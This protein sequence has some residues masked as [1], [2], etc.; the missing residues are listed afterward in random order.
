MN[1][2]HLSF[3]PLGQAAESYKLSRTIVD[4]L[5]TQDPS[6]TLTS[7]VIG[8]G[9]G[10]GG[11]PHI[12]ANYLA[13]SEELIQE[14]ESSDVVV[15]GTPMHNWTV[16]SALKAWIDHVIR[17][18]RTFHGTAQGKP[19]ALHDRPVFFAIASGAKFSGEGARQPDFLTP[20]LKFALGTIGLHDL[21]FF[22]IEG[23]G[24]ALHAVA[25]ARAEADRAVQEYF[26]QR[27]ARHAPTITP[28]APASTAS[29]HGFSR[30][31]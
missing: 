17:A 29:V 22:A 23:T 24:S 19:G 10:D 6:A 7:R 18:G 1:I 2:L 8:E 30:A 13:R 9:G 28:T 11:M 25:Q 15:I 16:P 3:S 12:D 5:L 20:Y 21:T 31:R 4:L 27:R 14:L 26:S